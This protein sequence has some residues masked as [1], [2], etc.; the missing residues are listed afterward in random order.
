MPACQRYSAKKLW[1]LAHNSYMAAWLKFQHKHSL[2]KLNFFEIVLS[3]KVTQGYDRYARKIISVELIQMVD[4]NERD[5]V[6]KSFMRAK[7]LSKCRTFRCN[8]RHLQL[9]ISKLGS[10]THSV[11]VIWMNCVVLYITLRDW[12]M[13]INPIIYNWL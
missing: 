11:F 2:K 8:E 13:R 4:S 5:R 6:K 3:Q 1:N 12:T 7:I 10:Y 9:L